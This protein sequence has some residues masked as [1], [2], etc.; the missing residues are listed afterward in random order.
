MGGEDEALGATLQDVY[1]SAVP[2]LC[3]S[4]SEVAPKA[5]EAI[6]AAEKADSDSSSSSSDSDSD[7]NEAPAGIV[8]GAQDQAAESVGQ[9]QAAEESSDD[10]SDSPDETALG[11][12][13]QIAA[14]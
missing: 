13:L 6:V 8:N 3:V 1:G 7:T 9:A 10:S 5:M 14:G 12:A 2:N 11:A 4:G